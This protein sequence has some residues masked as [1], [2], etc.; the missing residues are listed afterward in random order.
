[1]AFQGS[2]TPVPLI[3]SEGGF[4]LACAPQSPALATG[5]DPP[6]SDFLIGGSLKG[7]INLLRHFGGSS[8]HRGYEP[9]PTRFTF[10]CG[11]CGASRS[12]VGT[13]PTPRSPLGRTRSVDWVRGNGLC[14]RAT[15]PLAPAS[16]KDRPPTLLQKFKP[17][18]R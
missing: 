9:P 7:P 1:L 2:S 12:L 11:S 14:R 4:R 6:K 16:T 15:S 3:F 5:S 8:N 13:E 18:H 17:R 10:R